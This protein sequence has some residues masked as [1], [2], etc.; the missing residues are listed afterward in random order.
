MADASPEDLS[1][2]WKRWFRENGPRLLLFARG[3]TRGAADAEDVLQ[4]A[5]LRLWKSYSTESG[6]EPPPL[7]LAYTA[8]RHAAIDFARRNTRRT[9]REQKSDYLVSEEAPPATDWFGTG[10]LEERERAQEIQAALAK[11]P[12]KFREVLTLKIWGEQT[13][14]QIAEALDIP[15]NTAASRYRYALQALRK[16]LKPNSL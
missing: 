10:D 6:D 12:D 15:L 4:D 11:L 16:T 8:I 9:N 14:A 7:P 2:A 3:Q 13:F 5:I 1:E